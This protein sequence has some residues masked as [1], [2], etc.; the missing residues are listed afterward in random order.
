[1]VAFLE[2]EAE[3]EFRARHGSKGVRALAMVLVIVAM[4][5]TMVIAPPASAV[6]ITEVHT[7]LTYPRFIT[8]GPDGNLWVT[9][10]S[11]G[12]EPRCSPEEPFDGRIA[13]I[14]PAGVVTVFSNGI[15]GEPRDITAGPGG[16]LWFTVGV[17]GPS[18]HEPPGTIGRITPAGVVT[19]GFNTGTL[20]EG[21]FLEF[22]F[23]FFPGPYGIT[24]GAEGNLWV[25]I[26]NCGLDRCNDF[27]GEVARVTPEGTMTQFTTSSEGRAKALTL[28]HEGDLWVTLESFSESIPNGYRVARFSPEGVVTEFPLGGKERDF[29]LKDVTTGP[30]GNLWVTQGEVCFPE[31]CRPGHIARMTPTGTV[32]EFSR[33]ITGSPDQIT[34]GPDGNMWFTERQANRIGRIT[35]TGTVTE[36]S[37][38][39]SPGAEPFD[40]TAGPHRTLWFTEESG[41]IGRVK[42]NGA[43][44]RE[45]TSRSSGY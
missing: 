24:T 30:E 12:T 18:S 13:R 26:P 4:A 6:K 2:R 14:T 10:G 36:F 17:G 38:G 9:A 27:P 40:I 15:T 20:V 16:D 8:A 29:E 42:L 31:K 35:P 11:P 3:M 33:G 22:A 44:G 39:I 25:T 7:G 21:C 5:L 23:S 41:D 34:L 32:T 19:E 45:A 37:E 43:N 1:L 28:G